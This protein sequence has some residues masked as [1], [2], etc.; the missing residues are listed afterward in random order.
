MHLK[1][2]VNKK[3]PQKYIGHKFYFKNNR[4]QIFEQHFFYKTISQ[5]YF[6]MC[7][8]NISKQIFYLNILS[9]K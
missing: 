5:N 4:I 1:T 3:M 9:Q 8:E 7:V 2:I 6:F